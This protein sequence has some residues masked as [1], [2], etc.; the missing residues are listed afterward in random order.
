MRDV[1]FQDS[2]VLLEWRNLTEV[3]MFSRNQGL[4][5]KETHTQW[6]K[7]R[8]KLM[9]NE[10][11]WIFENSLGK[12]GFVRFDID[13][14]SKNY[15]ISI[16]INPAVRGKGFGKIVLGLAIENCLIRN[17]NSNFFAVAHRDNLSSQF[18]FLKSGFKVTAQNGDFLTYKRLTNLN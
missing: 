3:R 8:L 7:N 9:A 4:V 12:V 17:P 1:A 11:F 14:A 16:V 15:E 13:S 6:L 18:L 2:E 10:P 5:A